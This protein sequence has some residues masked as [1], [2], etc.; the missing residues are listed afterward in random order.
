MNAF[1]PGKQIICLA[2]LII[3]TTLAYLPGLSGGFLFDDQSN[4]LD[5]P[6]LGLFDGSLSSLIAASGSGVSSPFG[7]P[8][9]MASFA[10]NLHFFGASPFSFKLANLLI[11]LLN[12]VLIFILLQQLWPRLT[13]SNAPPLAATW[14]AAVWLLHPIN[15]TPVLFVVQRMTSLAALFSLAALI[16]YLQ[17]RKSGGSTG[18]L[19][20]A[21]G[22][23][24]FWPAGILAKE[25]AILLP[26]FILVCE[27]LTLNG[28]P[29][30]SRK[31]LW[32]VTL[33]STFTLAS[34]LIFEW[35]FLTAGY[36]FRDF[37]LIERL[38]LWATLLSKSFLILSIS[39]S[40]SRF[41]SLF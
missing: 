14:V 21:T 9:S 37:S 26:L 18:K 29:T 12:G 23:L 2:V 7:R 28:W 1:L 10:L 5:N 6:V 25:T 27:W 32:L 38:S 8:V 15:L 24:L 31:R 35:E 33:L 22:M 20:I 40:I 34:A 36:R 11:H 41:C 17:G 19:L 30:P 16:L 3:A 4:I 13:N 39:F